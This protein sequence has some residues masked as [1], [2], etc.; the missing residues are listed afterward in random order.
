MAA[1]DVDVGYVAG[2]LGLDQ[3]VVTAL[4]TEPTAELVATLLQAVAAKAHEF[5]TLY[6]DK[7]QTDIELENAVRSSENRSQAA[8]ATAE[9]ALK[10]VEDA[11]QKLKEEGMPLGF[12]C[13]LEP[14]TDHVCF[15]SFRDQATVFGE[16]IAGSEVEEFGSCR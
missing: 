15:A 13:W 6:A 10:E 4:T 2:H 3:P 7:L 1:A 8:K 9:K 11:R 12:I 14:I 5:D 16:R